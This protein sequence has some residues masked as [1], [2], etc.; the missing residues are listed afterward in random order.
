M[1]QS[2]EDE[3]VFSQ[4]VGFAVFL[5]AIP[6][7]HLLPIRTSRAP[8]DTRVEGHMTA[9]KRPFDQRL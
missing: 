3:G 4:P 9:A 8:S 1:R 6:T 5:A 7:P 2:K